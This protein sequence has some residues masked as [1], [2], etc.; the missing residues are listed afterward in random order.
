MEKVITKWGITVFACFVTYLCADLLISAGEPRPSHIKVPI[1]I[2]TALVWTVPVWMA[3]LEIHSRLR[4]VL[5][6]GL[7]GTGL[8]TSFVMISF[9]WL[10]LSGVALFHAYLITKLILPRKNDAESLFRADGKGAS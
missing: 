3:T 4:Y 8:V 7:L 10:V 5:A 1:G 9:G 2:A 6:A